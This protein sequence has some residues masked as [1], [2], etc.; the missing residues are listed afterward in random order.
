MG[1]I[2]VNGWVVGRIAGRRWVVDGAFGGNRGIWK[3]VSALASRFIE[4]EKLVPIK[5]NLL[6][7]KTRIKLPHRFP[8]IPDPHLHYQ[9][10]VYAMTH[11]NWR[12]FS[13]MVIEDL[14]AKM[15]KIKTVDLDRLSAMSAIINIEQASKRAR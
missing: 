12:Q 6:A 15:D 1:G 11:A 14:R 3:G 8:G 9:G 10:K 13:T 7:N 5:L 2:I 4:Q